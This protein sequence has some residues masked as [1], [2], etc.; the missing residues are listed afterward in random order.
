VGLEKENSIEG[1]PAVCKKKGRGGG[2][3]RGKRVATEHFNCLQKWGTL[4]RIRVLS[5]IDKQKRAFSGKS[6]HWRVRERENS[7]V[8]Q[9]TEKTQQVDRKVQPEK[10]SKMVQMEKPMRESG[11][12]TF[13]E[14]LERNARRDNRCHSTNC[15]GGNAVSSQ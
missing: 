6:E 11:K 12:E 7:Q 14:K 1:E 2:G 5:N 4:T 3:L 8:Y 9:K 10:R 15:R 13:G